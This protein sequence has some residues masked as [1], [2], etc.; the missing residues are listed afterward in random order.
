MGS[1]PNRAVRRRLLDRLAQTT[2]DIGPL[3]LAR[4][5]DERWFVQRNMLVLLERSARVPDGFSPARWTKHADARVRIEAIRL[6]LASPQERDT[7]I[8]AALGD[9][10]PRIVRLGLA[11]VQQRC[12]RDLVSRVIALSSDATLD[13][14][15]RVMAV[16]AI[17]RVRD[18]SALEA[19]LRLT[20]GGRTLFGRL[21]L[22]PK[23]S[24]LVAALRGLHATWAADPRAARVLAI[25]ARSSDSE[26][27]DAA[28][29]SS[30]V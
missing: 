22:P 6:Q 28:M 21:R 19:L 18:E 30:T 29:T 24:V 2:V 1:S 8:R 15:V 13:P 4:L 9:A 23:T 20:D 10:D 25:A 5:E 17:G 16:T 12:P 14:D 3:V 11:A 7:G 26:L 27:R